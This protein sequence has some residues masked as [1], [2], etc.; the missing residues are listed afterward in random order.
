MTTVIEM[1]AVKTAAVTLWVRARRL[2]YR[3]AL[4]WVRRQAASLKA[5]LDGWPERVKANEKDALDKRNKAKDLAD[6]LYQAR[7]KTI[8][9]RSD[10]ESLEKKH[11]HE[12]AVAEMKRLEDQLSKLN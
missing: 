5:E 7:M 1:P 8:E 4:L 6:A 11:A 2:Y 9:R 10:I 12:D 3:T